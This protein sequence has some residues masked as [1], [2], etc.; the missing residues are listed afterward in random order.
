MKRITIRQ[1]AQMLDKS[2]Q[3]VRVM[4]QKG[5]IGAITNESK[6][7]NTYYLTDTMIDDFMKGGRN[8]GR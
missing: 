2:E 7:R 5:L 6:Y 8:E 3:A 4:I 1:A